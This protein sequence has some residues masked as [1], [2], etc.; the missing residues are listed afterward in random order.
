MLRIFITTSLFFG[1]SLLAL[2]QKSRVLSVF[3]MI[4]TE[5]WED[6]KEAIELA[7][8]NPNLPASILIS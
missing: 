2:G 5:K 7:S 1:T 8:W 4:E 6:A 3:Q